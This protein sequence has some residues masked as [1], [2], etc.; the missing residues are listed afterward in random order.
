MLMFVLLCVIGS[1]LSQAHDHEL[2][3][4]TTFRSGPF[5]YAQAAV[6]ALKHAGSVE[7]TRSPSTMATRFLAHWSAGHDATAVD[8]NE[9]RQ[10]LVHVALPVTAASRA[11]LTAAVAPHEV[12]PYLP[13]GTFVVVAPRSHR[14]Q[15]ARAPSVMHVSEL[16][17]EHKFDP[18][19]MQAPARSRRPRVVTDDPEVDE[20]AAT[21]SHTHV[22][23]TL[24]RH[25]SARAS[26][27]TAAVAY[28]LKSAMQV[29]GVERM[30]MI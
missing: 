5:D 9:H 24:Q 20:P 3:H 1:A 21:T 19:D 13:H 16:L 12:G 30:M 26:T 28:R 27:S 29:R 11:A 15:L 25:A 14:A 4:V 2:P 18:A 10:F 6:T 8:A 7:E 17:P 22:I 23:V